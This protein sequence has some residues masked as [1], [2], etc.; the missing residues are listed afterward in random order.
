MLRALL[1]LLLVSGVGVGVAYSQEKEKAKKHWPSAEEKF[2]QLNTAGDGKLTLKE[3]LT[4]HEWGKHEGKHEGTEKS[5]AQTA[6]SE[7]GDRGESFAIKEFKS[8]DK[9]NKGYLTLAE[10]K[11]I[12]PPRHHGHR[13]HHDG[14]APSQTASGNCAGSNHSGNCDKGTSGH[15]HS[16]D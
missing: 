11:T 2:K 3:F 14:D 5:G 1:S 16:G 15:S 6:H 10:F 8:A 12:Y 4:G 7:H 9:G 13:H